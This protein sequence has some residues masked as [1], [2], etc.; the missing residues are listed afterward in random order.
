MDGSK[1]RAVAELAARQ[2][3]R[4]TAEQAR[5]LGFADHHREYRVRTGRWE[6]PHPGVYSIAG[7][8][9]SWHGL[10]LESCW[11]VHGLVAA[12]HRSAAALRD[13]PGGTRDMVEI[14]CDRWHRGFVAGLIVHETEL[15]LPEDIEE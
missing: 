12:S 1:D 7:T 8:P 11:A 5:G 4:F 9:D 15:L 2:H 3:G 6:S 14:T 10:L 13:L